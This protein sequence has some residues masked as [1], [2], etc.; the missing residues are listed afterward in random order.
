MEEIIASISRVIASDGG[1]R[2][3]QQPAAPEPDDILDLT[4]ALDREG[5][6][7][8]IEPRAEATGAVAP[9]PGE[10]T[11]GPARTEPEAPRGDAATVGGRVEPEGPRAGAGI[12]GGRAEPEGP[13]TDTATAGGRAEP[14]HNRILSE[15]ASRSAAAAFSRLGERPVGR[16]ASELPV[17]GANLTL[18]DIVRDTLRPLLQSWLDDH[19][20]AIVERLVREEIARVA[21]AAGTR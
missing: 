18:E 11:P 1:V 21:G 12:A 6:V 10:A 20:P 16:A 19:L 8:R 17:G 2:E 15:A 4:E 3:R 7:R 9:P 5:G 14:S 13:R